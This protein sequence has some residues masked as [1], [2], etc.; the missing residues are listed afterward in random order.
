MNEPREGRLFIDGTWRAAA[1]GGTFEVIN[2]ADESHVGTAADATAQDVADAVGAARRAFDTTDWPVD[3]EFRRHCLRQ[4][5]AGLKKTGPELAEMATLEAG[6]P[7]SQANLIDSVIEEV[8][9]T[10]GL[11]ERFP[12]GR[13]Q[14]GQHHLR[15]RGPRHRDPLQRRHVH[16]QQ[17]S[18][19]P[20]ADP[21]G[22]ARQQVRR[23]P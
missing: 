13:R 11:M 12:W 1:D 9:W 19:L 10:A 3:V 14:V 20:A 4:L 17:R 8:E 16:V 7:A 6:I 21:H 23:G 15:G 2:P 5:A 22:R 18:G